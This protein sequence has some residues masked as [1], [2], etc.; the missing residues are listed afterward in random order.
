M[1]LIRSPKKM[2]SLT[3]Q[4]KKEGRRIGFVPTMGYLHEG[5]L[6][7][8]RR[9]RKETEIVVVSIFVNPTQF[10]PNEDYKEYPRDLKRDKYL[11]KEVGTDIIFAPK[12]RDMYPSGYN[13]Y[14]DVEQLT[15]GLCGAFRPGHFRGVTT[16]VTKL[17]NIVQPDIAYF[18]QKDAQQAIVIKRMVQDLNMGVRIKVLPI[19]R[20]KDGLAMSSRNTYL[21]EEERRQAVTLYRSLQ[22]AKNL[23]RAGERK[24]SK[25]ISRMQHMIMTG[26]DK[27]KIDYIS[28]VDAEG[29][30]PLRYLQGC[31]LIALAVWVGKT[32]LIDNIIVRVEKSK[33]N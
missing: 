13:T 26:I 25:V 27:V 10:G 19:V 20:E 32:R 4:L 33:K 18:G 21:T 23:I 8:I 31:V 15:S 14:V 9:A 5:H 2:C 17:F 22:E 7:L 1:R 6:S 12:V 11:A 28:I 24:A 16:V 3:S 29:L 30:Q